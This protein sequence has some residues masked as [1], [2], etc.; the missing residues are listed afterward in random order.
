MPAT[1]IVKVFLASS[2]TELKHERRDISA[3]G[4]DISNLVSNDNI[5]VRFI[6]CDNFHEG[7][8][9]EHDLK[10]IDEKIR[11]CD[12]SMF[13]FKTKAGE[14]TRHEYDVARALQ[15]EQNHR[16]FIYFFPI[17]DEKKEPSLKNFQ[18]QLFNDGI[19]WEECERLSEVR[20]KI[21]SVR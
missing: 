10:A 1:R 13:V 14:W 12:I 19:F 17:P 5:V 4:D 2:I 6:K 16:I 20:L 11:G 7:N 3:L 15:K 21:I 8:L 9:G 18:R